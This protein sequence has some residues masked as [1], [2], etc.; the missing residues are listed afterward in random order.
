MDTSLYTDSAGE[1]ATPGTQGEAGLED[2]G[3]SGPMSLPP[4]R[5]RLPLAVWPTLWRESGGKLPV[6]P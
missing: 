3:D 4:L 6:L 5:G 1:L 2:R